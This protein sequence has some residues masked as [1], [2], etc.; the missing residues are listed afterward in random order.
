MKTY[1]TLCSVVASLILATA[2]S[3]SQ[4]EPQ[5]KMRVD[6]KY[7]AIL[8]AAGIEGEVDINV[9]VDEQ[10][11]ITKIDTSKVS[12]SRFVPVVFDAIRQ[13]QFEPAMKN[14]VPIKAEIAIPFKF[15]IGERSYRS[16]YESI[17]ALKDKTERILRR[18]ISEDLEGFV[19]PK[20]YVVIGHLYEPLLSLLTN[21][22]KASYLVEGSKSRVEF[23]N[24]QTDQSKSSAYLTLKTQPNGGKIDR[25]HTI[26]FMQRPSGEWRI[27]AWHVSQ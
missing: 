25:F 15:R 26:V 27:E 6:P 19:D 21:P 13:W 7:P 8:K 12:D 11:K 14:G 9:S 3:Y 22:E 16:G 17:F 1:L 5:V 4:E 24:L 18:G 2:L 23:S 20:A 10:G